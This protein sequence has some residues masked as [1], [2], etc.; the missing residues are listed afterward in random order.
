MK[1]IFELIFKDSVHITYAVKSTKEEDLILMKNLIIFHEDFEDLHL[2]HLLKEKFPSFVSMQVF[3][4]NATTTY[5]R[6]E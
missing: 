3:F 1:V 5:T 2:A 6:D 4:G